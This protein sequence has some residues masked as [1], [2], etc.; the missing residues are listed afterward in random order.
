MVEHLEERRREKVRVL[1]EVNKY[2]YMTISWKIHWDRWFNIIL[3]PFSFFF[4][5]VNPK[6]YN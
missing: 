5:N 4:F 2:I 3:P 6:K 1:L